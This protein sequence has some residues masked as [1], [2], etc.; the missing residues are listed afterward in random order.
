MFSAYNV[1]MNVC[2]KEK[3]LNLWKHRYQNDV[4]D[5]SSNDERMAEKVCSAF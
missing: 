2:L 4:C 3:R 1:S 5:I